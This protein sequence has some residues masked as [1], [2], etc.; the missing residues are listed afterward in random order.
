M[1]VHTLTTTKERDR[2][3]AIQQASN[4]ASTIIDII[5]PL[6]MSSDTNTIN[7]LDDDHRNRLMKIQHTISKEPLLVQAEM[8]KK[9][10]VNDYIHSLVITDLQLTTEQLTQENEIL[11]EENEMIK[12][13]LSKESLTYDAK[14]IT[15]SR[16]QNKQELDQL[17]RDLESDRKITKSLMQ[18][19]L[20]TKYSKQK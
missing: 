3:Q 19:I 15:K 9:L 1:N 5:S 11:T 18:N 13:V 2:L 6:N 7:N 8:S 10:A 20:K 17:K 16:E 4:H 12:D 14:T